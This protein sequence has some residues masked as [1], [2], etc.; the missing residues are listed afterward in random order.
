MKKS[1]VINR[2]LGA[3][4]AVC[5]SITLCP[6]QTLAY[7]VTGYWDSAKPTYNYTLQ[8]YEIRTPEE[9]QYMAT[10]Q[11]EDYVL[12]A[13]IDLGGKLF[14]PIV[15]GESG[16]FDGQGHT[17]TGWE[18]EEGVLF[19]SVYGTVKNVVVRIGKTDGR[20]ISLASSNQ[21]RIENCKAVGI[22]NCDILEYCDKFSYISY[23][24]LVLSNIWGGVVENCANY[25]DMRFTYS[26]PSRYCDG[27]SV[28]GIVRENVTVNG[29]C[30]ILN[31]INYGDIQF[32]APFDS[33]ESA[34]S[35]PHAIIGGIAARNTVYG[36]MNITI[37]G[38]ENK[39]TIYSDSTGALSPVSG[40][41]ARCGH[42]GASSGGTLNIDHCKNT[43]NITSG[44]E[45]GGI[46]GQAY[47]MRAKVVISNCANEGNLS[48]KYDEYNGWDVGGIVGS[49]NVDSS[50]D[51]SLTIRNCTN[52]GHLNGMTAGGIL[53][54]G[55]LSSEGDILFEAHAP[56]DIVN[57]V[58]K[59]SITGIDTAGIV[60]S[61]LGM[62]TGCANL[63]T[64]TAES[65]GSPAGI[66]G[67]NYTAGV[68]DDCGNSGNIVVNGAGNAAGIA[69]INKGAVRNSYN[70]GSIQKMG[71][72]FS[73][74]AGIVSRND[75][76]GTISTCFAKQTSIIAGAAFDGDIAGICSENH[77]KISDCYFQG[78]LSSGGERNRV[79]AI[80]MMSS[81][82]TAVTEGCY[83]AVTVNVP[84]DSDIYGVANF[85]T[86]NTASACY[87]N[88]AGRWGEGAAKLTLSEMQSAEFPNLL[89]TRSGQVDARGVWKVGNPYPEL[90][91]TEATYT[92]P[93]VDSSSFGDYYATMKKRTIRVFLEDVLY[94][95]NGPVVTAAMKDIEGVF[96]G[97]WGGAASNIVME[98]PTD[99]TGEITISCEGY[100]SQTLPAELV[101]N[102]NTVRLWKPAENGKPVLQSVLL[103][104]TK[105][106]YTSF[107]NLISDTAMLSL[108]ENT[109]DTYNIYIDVD[110]GTCQDHSLKL[111]QGTKEIALLNEGWNR[112][113]MLG[114][115]LKQTGG[116]VYIVMGDNAASKGI[117]VKVYEAK[118]INVGIETGDTQEA[119]MPDDID[120]IGGVNLKL[121]LTELSKNVIP[122]YFELSDDGIVKGTIGLALDQP[123]GIGHSNWAYG[124]LKD[125]FKSW[126]NQSPTDEQMNE[127][128]KKM[129][130]SGIPSHSAKFGITADV[131]VLGYCEGKLGPGG[132]RFTECG[133]IMSV[134][135]K[136]S[137][138]Q[139][140][141][142]PVL[143]I[144]VYY[145][146]GMKLKTTLT[147]PMEW[148]GGRL[149]AKDT[150]FKV[151]LTVYGG[152]GVGMPKLV[153]GGVRGDGELAMDSVFPYDANHAEWTLG[154]NG[155]FV[156]SIFGMSGEWQIWDTPP[157]F[158]IYKDGQ[159]FP[160]K[161]TLQSM[162]SSREMFK[163]A[164]RNYLEDDSAF[165]ANHAL[166]PY[167]T[168]DG[169]QSLPI[170]DN[171]YTYAQPQL[172]VFP[173][174]CKLLVWVDDMGAESRYLGSN[175]TALFY[176]YFDGKTWSE[177]AL[178]SEDTGKAAY[179]P[180]LRCFQNTAYLVWNEADAPF[181]SD[182]VTLSEVSRSMG[183]SYA[184][185]DQTT[186]NF[187]NYN[188]LTSIDDGADLL[189]EI[190]LVNGTPVVVWAN[191]SVGDFFFSEGDSTLKKAEWTDS[192][193][194]V[195]S[196]DIDI[197]TIDK[198]ALQEVD[199]SL[200]VYYSRDYDGDLSDQNDR[201]IYCYINGTVNPMTDNEVA[202]SNPTM[203][204]EGLVWYQNGE[205]VLDGKNMAAVGGDAYQ[206]VAGAQGQAA[207][208]YTK[209]TQNTSSLCAVFSDGTGWSNEVPVAE[210][211]GFIYDYSGTFAPDGSLSV[212]VT[213][214]GNDK[215]ASLALYN[216]P[217]ICDIGISSVDYDMYSLIPGKTLSMS[218]NIKNVGTVAISAL[219]VNIKNEEK[220]LCDT[221]VGVHI[222]PGEEVSIDLPC[223][224]PDTLPEYLHIEVSPVGAEDIALENNSF[225]CQ[226]RKEDISIE[227]ASAFS[228]NETTLVTAQ[229]ANRGVIEL[230]DLIVE[231]HRD[232][233]NGTLLY[234][235]TLDSVLP[236]ENVNLSYIVDSLLPE[237]ESVYITIDKTENENIIN[238]NERYCVVQNLETLGETAPEWKNLTCS[239]S[240]ELSGTLCNLSSE[241]ITGKVILAA[242][243]ESGKE[244]SAIVTSFDLNAWM[245]HDIVWKIQ[246]ADVYKV[247]VLHSN[248]TPW[249]FETVTPTM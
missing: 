225:D 125:A 197:A 35:T 47:R 196:L 81:N 220:Y 11:H 175:R 121:D 144:P 67:T 1:T 57:C 104:Q 66:T 4:L 38:C 205:L 86:T 166:S 90:N 239:D 237:G 103:D 168:G 134:Q 138:I 123:G 32:I 64:V 231:V 190:T 136:V 182:E 230:E 8:A 207:I 211:Q 59:G 89:D 101:G 238:N 127:L 109:T 49:V 48:V 91:G 135:G 51:G 41:A 73:G 191:N 27:I 102:F 108:Y 154:A 100:L 195:E 98:I 99:Y 146:A 244:L 70:T 139:Q 149:T 171:V 181:E 206:F 39:G 234:Q 53:G 28:A 177:P 202:D 78:T 183:I 20:L 153:T 34:A 200:A 65:W 75:A 21:G 106:G 184:Q 5:V 55:C 25:V 36:E 241:T 155:Y 131:Q 221:L 15:V 16:S 192:G 114:A 111:M 228:V 150:S 12:C 194:H 235:D 148:L 95:V 17:I 107:S 152:T 137:Y 72:R 56:I 224:L 43:G 201:E 162:S 33:E 203:T 71:G 158:T 22:V 222:L 10:H 176:S 124:T 52:T 215:T 130:K 37:S 178:V 3:V 85:G 226:L 159:W 58:N 169:I 247:F 179:N 242:Y 142:L 69:A 82:E 156:G 9:L 76:D 185:F 96:Y 105:D 61:N 14:E 145:E 243:D 117:S 122:L 199:G 118:P 186:G 77:G 62:V 97:E 189:P 133:M 2:L 163:L 223:D 210:I 236:G 132:I 80:C 128:I 54:F 19:S 63:G 170:K 26:D 188:S 248:N 216:I 157:S 83:A 88:I 164:S 13:D 160:R 209:H 143:P 7:D 198:I 46:F 213:Q 129:N 29:N 147:M 113:L 6:A 204:D 167:N 249:L 115:H 120:G 92:K 93:V 219:N 240:N 233:S 31:C 172:A 232:T 68:I 116:A 126:E 87:S 245:E 84:E 74:L 18:N 45:T 161:E 187:T 227:F 30:S 173:D 165:L 60:S 214:W 119:T 140:A 217:P 44:T 218:A 23:S 50:Y 110:W 208:L 42:S 24:P 141:F 94:T 174:N 180:V 193:W 151:K 229:V 212:A 79:A 40:I 246:E 112:N